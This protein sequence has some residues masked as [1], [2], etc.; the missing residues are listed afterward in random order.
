V[1][2]SRNTR[3]WNVPQPNSGVPSTGDLTFA[4]LG[5]DG[6]AGLADIVNSFSYCAVCLLPPLPLD[7]TPRAGGSMRSRA[8][9][10]P[11]SAMYSWRDDGCRWNL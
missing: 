10:A 9:R 11:Q 6:V 8:S 4:G 3:S 2:T 5:D 7:G 1:Q